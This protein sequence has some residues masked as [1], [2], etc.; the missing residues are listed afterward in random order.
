VEPLVALQTFEGE[1]RQ[2]GRYEGRA[3]QDAAHRAN[4]G[5]TIA[6]CESAKVAGT[7]LSLA[8]RCAVRQERMGLVVEATSTRPRGAVWPAE[9]VSSPMTRCCHSVP[10]HRSCLAACELCRELARGHEGPRHLWAGA[11][12]YCAGHPRL[13]VATIVV[14]SCYHQRD[15][16][17]G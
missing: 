1:R 14:R 12:G 4:L 11:T 13:S 6:N 10:R 7:L 9:V 8:S 17:S 3:T 2:H 16:R 15:R 5:A